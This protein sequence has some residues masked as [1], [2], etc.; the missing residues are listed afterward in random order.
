[1][2][3]AELRPKWE[4]EVLVFDCPC[5]QGHRLR[6]PATR[7]AEKKKLG[8]TVWLIT[9]DSAANY[10]LKPSIDAP[11]WH[12]CITNGEVSTVTRPTV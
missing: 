10:T 2:K 7:Y 6:V 12:G 11:C 9:G 5:G 8:K 1:V 4:R 3:L